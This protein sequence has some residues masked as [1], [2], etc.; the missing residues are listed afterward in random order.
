[1]ST[2]RKEWHQKIEKLVKQKKENHST[3]IDQMMQEEIE[4]IKAEN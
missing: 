3:K 2:C 1:M 4:E